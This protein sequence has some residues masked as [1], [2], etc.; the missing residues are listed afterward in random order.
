MKPNGEPLWKHQSEEFWL[1]S[2]PGGRWAIGGQDVM[3]DGFVRSSG[4]IFQERSH[5]GK[6][7]DRVPGAWWQW[8]GTAFKPNPDIAVVPSWR[9]AKAVKKQL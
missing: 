6:F 1:F 7:P 5:H 3:E 9:V 8:D 2:T 4:W